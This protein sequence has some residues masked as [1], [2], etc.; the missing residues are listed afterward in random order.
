MNTGTHT[1]TPK[2]PLSLESLRELASARTYYEERFGWPVTI[3]VNGG[4]LMMPLGEV[5][6][7]VVMPA[8]LGGKVLTELRIALLAGP[9]LADTTGQWW[10]FLTRPAGCGRPKD[11]TELRSL[12]VHVVPAG[13]HV[14]I[15]REID[16]NAGLPWIE[17][18]R[19][20]HQLPPWQC[21]IATV[22]R[23][24]AGP[25]SPGDVPAQRI[26]DLIQVR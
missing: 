10:M 5:A 2:R 19:A 17:R 4:R 25:T 16:E 14:V 7:A 15:P 13:S 8:P 9:V 12:E 6:D 18:P 3:E 23:S 1:G 20:L 11:H 24:G 21:V 26:G 22:R